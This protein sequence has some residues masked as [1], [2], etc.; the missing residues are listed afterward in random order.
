MTE[1]RRMAMIYRLLVVNSFVWASTGLYMPFIGAY[2]TQ[3]GITPLQVGVLVSIGPVISILIQ[4]LW[5][6]MSDRSGRHRLVLIIVSLGSGAAI[7]S[8]LVRVSFGAFVVATVLVSIFN[9]AIQPLNDALVTNRAAKL[10]ANFA[11]LRIGGTIGF[12]VTALIMGNFLKSRAGMIFVLGSAGYFLLAAL[13]LLLP[14]DRQMTGRSREQEPGPNAKRIFKNRQIYLVLFLAF[15]IQL[16]LSFNGTFYPVYVISLG[17]GQ[18]IVGLSSFVSA[19]SEIPILLCANRLIRRFGAVHLLIFSVLMMEGK[20]SQGQSRLA[21]VQAG[22]G[23]VMGNILGGLMTDYLGVRLSFVV[24]SVC[25]LMAACLNV[26]L[27]SLFNRRK[28]GGMVFNS[29]PNI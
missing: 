29:T 16:G 26:G 6:Y 5:A 7:L 18:S 9:T 4:P 2:Y 14:E 10:D 3:Q 24:M 17:Y 21:M 28:K 19:M 22:M 25:V 15:I 23:A 1:G 12:A 8:Y 13:F 20:M 27:I 11:H